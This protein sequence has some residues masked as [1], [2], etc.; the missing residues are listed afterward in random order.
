MKLTEIISDSF[1]YPGSNPEHLNTNRKRWL[2]FGLIMF[3]TY[4][5]LPIIFVAGFTLRV[6]RKTIQGD[7]AMPEFNE[8]ISMFI[9]GVKVIAATIIY[10]LAPVVFIILG[11][12]QYYLVLYAYDLADITLINWPLL[13]VGV[14]LFI[15]FLMFYMMAIANMAYHN[16]FGAA[17]SMGE[18]WQRIRTVGYG[19]FILWWLA[20]MLVSAIFAALGEMVNMSIVGFF[21]VP[22]VFESF[23]ALFQAR[24]AGLIYREGQNADVIEGNIISDNNLT[25]G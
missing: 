15:P 19:K 21:L 4:V 25:E 22:I 5:L 8:W 18:I 10:Y 1:K 13:I 23:I 17:F 2:I 7:S 11:A 12:G 3:T 16:R 9:D 6:T 20:T 24:S 14:L